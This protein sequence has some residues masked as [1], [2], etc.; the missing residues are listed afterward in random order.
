MAILPN[1]FLLDRLHDEY[2]LCMQCKV[3]KLNRASD[4]GTNWLRD[5][6]LNNLTNSRSAK[7]KAVFK[8]TIQQ[9]INGKIYKTMYL[10]GTG[11]NFFK[12]WAKR[13][14]F[15]TRYVNGT[16]DEKKEFDDHCQLI[17]DAALCYD[18][19][20]NIIHNLTNRRYD[21]LSTHKCFRLVSL[22]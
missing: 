6:M 11:V 13:Q 14:P 5:S 8:V 17:N 10:E 18:Y 19:W 15:Y 16:E 21:T 3:I 2:C 12:V 20:E 4:R 22:P 7:G 1:N 9:I